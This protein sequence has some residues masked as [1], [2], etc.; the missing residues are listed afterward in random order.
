MICFV[1]D[2]QSGFEP[3]ILALLKG[4][5]LTVLSLEAVLIAEVEPPVCGWTHDQLVAQ[6]A[7]LE[8]KTA[9][10]AEAYLGGVWVGSTEV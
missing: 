10:G 5:R 3:D 4:E 7:S 1:T 8:G 9:G 6:A 2:I